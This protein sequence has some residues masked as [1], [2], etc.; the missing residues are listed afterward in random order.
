MRSKSMRIGGW[1]AMVALAA[2]A[3]A[4][5][6]EAPGRWFVGAEGGFVSHRFETTYEYMN[7][8]ASDQYVDRANGG[9]IAVAFGYAIPLNKQFSVDILG[10]IAGNNAEWTLDTVDEY[11]GTDKGGPARLTFEIPYFY[12][13]MV[14]PHI[15]LPANFSLFG[16]AGLRYGYLHFKKVSDSSTRYEISEWTPGFVAGGGLQFDALRN[17]S[18]YVTYRYATFDSGNT[19]SVFPDGTPWEKVEVKSR[20]QS[21]GVGAVY[22]F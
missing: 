19:E 1:L 4:A 10:R 2:C 9:E 14:R 7:G 6:D 22:V 15:S 16:E 20:T 5:D 12:D 17:L 13:A 18:L 11:S 3:G 21:V 8:G